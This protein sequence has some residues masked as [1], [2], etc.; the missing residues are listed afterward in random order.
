[1][2]MSRYTNKLAFFRSLTIETEYNIKSSTLIGSAQSND[3][4]RDF[5]CTVVARNLISSRQIGKQLTAGALQREL[6]VYNNT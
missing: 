5:T 3:L 2:K 1:M 6:C 4:F